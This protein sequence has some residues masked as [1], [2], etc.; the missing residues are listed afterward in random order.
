MRVDPINSASLEK[1]DLI[2]ASLV[3]RW[4]WLKSCISDILHVTS[5]LIGRLQEVQMVEVESI[6]VVFVNNDI[7]FIRC[8]T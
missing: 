8:F 3:K 5:N 6:N 2:C 4:C 7:D 1:T